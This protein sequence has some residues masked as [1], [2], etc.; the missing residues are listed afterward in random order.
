M[1]KNTRNLRNHLVTVYAEHLLSDPSMWRLAVSY[2]THCGEVGMNTAG[3]ILLHLPFRISGVNVETEVESRSLAMF[4]GT[5]DPVAPVAELDDIIDACE[6]YG[7][8]EVKQ[9]ICRVCLF[10]LIFLADRSFQRS[11]LKN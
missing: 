6:V 9:A 2:L 5:G 11:P 4:A 10:S 7:L 1:I 3:E 8:K